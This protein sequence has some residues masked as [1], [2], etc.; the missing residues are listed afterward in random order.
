MSFLTNKDQKLVPHKDEKQ[1]MLLFLIYRFFLKEAKNRF[2]YES[3][4]FLYA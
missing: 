2:L 1:L 4:I 3:L